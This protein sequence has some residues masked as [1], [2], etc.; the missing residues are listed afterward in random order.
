MGPYMSF[1]IFFIY[2]M[3]YALLFTG[4]MIFFVAVVS[5]PIPCLPYL[6]DIIF[7]EIMF[8]E[9]QKKH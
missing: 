4:S 3:R 2:D 7:S 5:F 8:L 1:V 6:S 9:D